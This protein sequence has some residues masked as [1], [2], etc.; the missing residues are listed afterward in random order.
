[1]K[2][3]KYFSLLKYIPVALCIILIILYLTN[4]D[5]ITVETILNYTPHNPITAA[6][7]IL[8]L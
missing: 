6:F 8:F 1:M 4:K 2:N 7:V 5:K 3:K